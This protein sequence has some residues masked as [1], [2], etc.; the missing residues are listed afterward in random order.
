MRVL[1]TGGGGFIGRHLAVHLARRS[2]SVTVLDNLTRGSFELLSNLGV[3]C[4]Q[5]DIRDTATLRR[6][7]IR[8][9][10]VFHLAAQS[11]VIGAAQDLDYSFSTNVL[12]T[13]NVLRCASDSGVARVVFTSSREVYGEVERLPVPETEPPNPKNSYGASKAAGELYCRTFASKLEVVVLRLANVY[14]P[15]DRDRVIPI[16]LQNALVG[17]PLVIFGA[18]KILDFVS[19][20]EVLYCLREAAVRPVAGFTINVGSGHGT[21]LEALACRILHVTASSSAIHSARARDI[22]IDRYIADIEKSRK[23]LDFVPFAPLAF[24]DQTARS[25]AAGG[26]LQSGSIALTAGGCIAPGSFAG[27]ST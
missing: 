13:F 14:G 26:D 20:Y 9:D 22:E 5:D 2:H 11:N 19:I 10:L 6:L 12:G 16:F 3:E 4:V 17:E 25:K 7:M 8:T 21:T 18:G 15:G 27:S 23:C 24:L 1:V